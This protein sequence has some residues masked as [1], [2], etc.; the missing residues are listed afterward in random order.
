MPMIA[1]AQVADDFGTY[2]LRRVGLM[3]FQGS[4]VDLVRADELQLAFYSEFSRTTPFELVLLNGADLDEVQASDAHRRGW[5]H[6]TTIIEVARR[7]RLDA[8]LF[9]TV[10]REQF[11]PPQELST[12]V[13]MVA[14]ETGLVIWSS[15]AHLS[16]GDE[17]VQ[18]G[19][20]IYYDAETEGQSA[21]ELALVSPTRFARFAAYQIASML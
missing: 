2:R 11:F 19:L 4:N 16:A 6:P 20:K 7:Y 10:V 9:G 18:R 5:Y 1:S 17:R 21:W 13:D 12:Q 14:A 15:V 8:I 3:P